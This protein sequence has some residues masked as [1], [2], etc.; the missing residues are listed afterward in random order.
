MKGQIKLQRNESHG[1]SLIELMVVIAIISTLATIAMPVARDLLSQAKTAEATTN[2]RLLSALIKAYKVEF[3]AASFMQQVSINDFSSDTSCNTSAANTFGFRLTSCRNI[4]Y[5]YVTYMTSIESVF[6]AAA[7][8]GKLNG[9]KRV[10]PRCSNNMDVWLADGQG[11]VYHPGNPRES[12]SICYYINAI[13][14]TGS[15]EV[16]RI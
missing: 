15:G 2:V 1:F 8:E 13:A 12:C 14:S 11:V 10:Y 9:T 5:V 7:Y 3:P 6:T 4:G 16:P